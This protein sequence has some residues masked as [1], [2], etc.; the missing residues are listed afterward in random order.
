MNGDSSPKRILYIEEGQDYLLEPEDELPFKLVR[1]LGQGGC[2]NVEEVV[3]QHTGRVFA[4]KVFGICGSR[5]ERRR[6]FDNEIRTIRRLAPHHHITRVFATYVGRRQIGILLTPVADRGS[7]DMFLQDAH[8]G[9]LTQSELNTLNYSFGCHAE[10][11]IESSAVCRNNHR[12]TVST[13][14]QRVL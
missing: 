2:A 5:A 4:R 12:H 13:P 9:A 14:T 6:I 7:L 10:R 1:N 11:R 3:D 8:D